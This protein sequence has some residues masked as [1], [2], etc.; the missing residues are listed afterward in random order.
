MSL[1]GLR[2]TRDFYMGRAIMLY[3]TAEGDGTAIL[4]GDIRVYLIYE[5]AQ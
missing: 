2:K 4:D 3:G 1:I 5:G